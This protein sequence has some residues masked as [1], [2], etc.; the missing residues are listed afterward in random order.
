MGY[1]AQANAYNGQQLIYLWLDDDRPA[2]EG[3]IGVT[4]IFDAKLHLETG[5]VDRASL[6]H[7]LGACE[8][9]MDGMDVEEWLEAHHFRTMPHCKHVG[10]GYGPS[11]LD[12]PERTTGQ[13]KSQP[14]T[15]RTESDVAG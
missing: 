9:C 5:R 11:R 6:N 3:W 2:S 13:R 12:G 1:L 15:A 4:T 10:T 14:F 8:T 7:H